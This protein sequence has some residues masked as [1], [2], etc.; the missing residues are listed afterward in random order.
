MTPHTPTGPHYSAARKHVRC[1]TAQPSLQMML[2][3]ELL[4]RDVFSLLLPPFQK[5]TPKMP[6]ESPLKSSEMALEGTI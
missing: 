5:F 6:T 3:K 2:E 4:P 1:H